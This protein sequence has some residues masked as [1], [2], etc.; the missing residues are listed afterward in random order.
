MTKK[1]EAPATAIAQTKHKGVIGKPRTYTRVELDAAKLTYLMMGNDRSLEII[2]KYSGITK[3]TLYDYAKNEDWY[4]W[5]IAEEAALEKLTLRGLYD[6]GVLYLRN[7]ATVIL[8]RIIDR[9]SDLLDGD[10]LSIKGNDVTTAAHMIL[11]LDDVNGGGRDELLPA[12]P[13][14]E[15]EEAPAESGEEDANQ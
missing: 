7:K 10:E 14:E 9:G 6:V 12:W 8:S 13:V 1:K 3:S 11:E 2:A 5:V 15:E 4:T